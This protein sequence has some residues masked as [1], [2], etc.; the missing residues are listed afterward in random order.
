LSVKLSI[1]TWHSRLYDFQGHPRSGSSWGDDL[2]PLSGLFFMLFLPPIQQRQSTEGMSTEGMVHMHF[3]ALPLCLLMFIVLFYAKS[4]CRT[5]MHG[6]RSEFR[7]MKMAHACFGSLLRTTT[8]LVL[9]FTLSGR[10]T[11]QTRSAFKSESRVT[12]MMTT[13]VSQSVWRCS[14]VWLLIE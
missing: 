13:Q 6:N 14:E 5:Y 7:R 9:V 11:L 2:S 10:L 3:N 4:S 8:T 12:K 1:K